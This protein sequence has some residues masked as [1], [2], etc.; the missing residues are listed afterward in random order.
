MLLNNIYNKYMRNTRKLL[1]FH[2]IYISQYNA[3][4]KVLNYIFMH[5]CYGFNL[6]NYASVRDLLNSF[7]KLTFSVDRK[8]DD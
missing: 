4:I 7:T 3:T 6:C 2:F 1:L 8:I 5:F